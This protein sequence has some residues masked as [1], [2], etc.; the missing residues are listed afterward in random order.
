M[1]LSRDL[2]VQYKTAFVLSH[3][4]REAMASRISDEKLSGNVEVDCG[5]F[6]GYVK[7]ANRVEQR[8]D[9]RLVKNQSGKRECVVIMRERNGRSLPFVVKN[10]AASAP[11]VKEHVAPNS[12]VYAD[13]ASAWDVLHASYPDKADQSFDLLFGRRS[14]HELGGKLLLTLAPRRS[15][16]SPSY[17]RSVSWTVCGR[18]GL[19]RRSSA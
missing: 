16:H 19:A 9:L 7:P 10:E 17:R 12:T 2:N 13:D 6:G 8:R 11:A 3:K 1:Q 14:L 15:R 18:N 4:I 5:F